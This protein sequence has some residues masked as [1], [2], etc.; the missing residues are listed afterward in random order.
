MHVE[1]PIWVEVVY[2]N[3]TTFRLHASAIEHTE[4]IVRIT[5]LDGSIHEVDRED[6]ERIWM[7]P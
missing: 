3:G 1:K 2:K 4:D 5:L 7:A 6:A